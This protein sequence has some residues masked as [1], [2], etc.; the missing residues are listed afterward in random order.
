MI[1]F[2]VPAHDE[3]RFI[4]GTLRGLHAAAA[5]L[6][7]PYEIVVVDDASTDATA[8][9]AAA[10]GARVV[11]VAHRKIS[12][13]RNAGAAEARG[14]LLV[15]VDADTQVPGAVL[16]SA[17][18]AVRSGAV[19][20]GARGRFEGPISLYARVLALAWLWLQR[21]SSLA[22]GCFLFCT[23]QAFDA[24]GGF[25]ERLYAAEDVELSSRLKRLGR[26]VIVRET[27]VTSGRSARALSAAEALRILIPFA[28]RGPRA[29]TKRR[30]PWYASRR[31]EPGSPSRSG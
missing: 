19:G 31:D 10:E 11:A 6:G 16:R 5:S 27:V 17:V 22:M 30:G 3:A 26:F 13:A 9:L 29:F 7:E 15:F 1:S 24:A 21:L 28:L 14:E 4:V 8:A 23:R 20:G 25:D 2:V 12:A 18:S